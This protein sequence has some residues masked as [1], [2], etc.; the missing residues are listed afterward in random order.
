ML[1]AGQ[2][3]VKESVSLFRKALR[4][5]PLHAPTRTAY[6]LV[7]A[8]KVR[9]Y[10]LAEKHLLRSLELA[11]TSVEA[12]HH[13]GRLYEEQ[14]ASM[15]DDGTVGM[16]GQKVAHE[17]ALQCYRNCLSV[18]SEHVPTLIRMGMLLSSHTSYSS[19]HGAID[20]AQSCLA[21]AVAASGETNAD[22]H[23]A[24]GTFLY[25]HIA[26]DDRNKR[27]RARRHL[28]K[29]IEIDEFHVL[30]IDELAS[31]FEDEGD[32]ERAEELWVRALDADVSRAPSRA[33]FVQLLERVRT[34]CYSVEEELLHSDDP[35]VA[36]RLVLHQQLRKYATLKAIYASRQAP[37]NE[38]NA[39]HIRHSREFLK[40]FRQQFKGNV[41][42]RRK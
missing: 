15:S 6:A 3:K 42:M 39:V 38:E 7:L 30:A 20:A 26:A 24:Y 36:K 16:D 18:D 41:T 13:L 33:D 21:R 14:V 25:S 11:P 28:E 34:R 12:L 17:R 10:E 27:A 35:R 9:D 19:G 40:A 8:Y 22:A 31:S 29:A 1:R 4:L 23:Y 32:L 37:E 2:D 5:D